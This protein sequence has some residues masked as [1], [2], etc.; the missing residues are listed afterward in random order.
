MFKKIEIW[1]LYLF[2][3]IFFIILIL[4][5][6]ILNHH[7]LGGTKFKPIQNIAKFI[8]QIPTNFKKIIEKAKEPGIYFVDTS[9]RFVDKPTS[10]IFSK[11]KLSG[12]LLLP[13]YDGDIHKFVVEVIDLK[14]FK[15]LHKFTPDKKKILNAF[16]YKINEQFKSLPSIINE[17]FKMWHPYLE[18]NGGL[19]FNSDS[20]LYKIDFCSNIEWV[21]SDFSFHH[22]LEIDHENNYWTPVSFNPS[23]I[24]NDAFKNHSG[25]DGIAKISPDGKTLYKKSVTQILIDNGYTHLLYSQRTYS[26]DTIHLNDIQ[27]VLKDG[28]YWNKGDL[29]LSS[30]SLSAIILYRPSTNKIIKMLRSPSFSQQH[31]VDIINDNVIYIFNNNRYKTPTGTKIFNNS[32]IISYDFQTQKYSKKYKSAI[33]GSEMKTAFGGLFQLLNNGNF[34]IEEQEHGRLLIFNKEEEL[35]WEFVNKSKKNKVFALRWSRIIEDQSIIKR[36]YKKL[37]N[38][39]CSKKKVN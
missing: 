23:L 13:R 3:V 34:M 21:N 31:D 37:E 4:F 24:K 8:A 11:E 16:N 14:T 25:D 36:F 28:P 6:G 10:R 22:S 5:G 7:Y 19:V 15:I 30:K 18:R 33:S 38:T 9:N 26:Y 20:P 35:I 1:I 17:R 39:K 27:P 12:L 32:E 2:F 29:F